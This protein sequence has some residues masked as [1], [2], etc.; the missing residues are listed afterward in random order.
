MLPELVA[1]ALNLDAEHLHSGATLVL[2][3]EKGER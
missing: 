2:I 1:D 3:P